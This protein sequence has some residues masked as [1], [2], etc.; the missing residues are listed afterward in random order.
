M[1]ALW[2]ANLPGGAYRNPILYADYS[3]PDIICVGDDFYMVA[4]SF[5]YLPGVP[6]LHS[7]DL[8]NWEI[9]NYCVQSLPFAHYDVPQHGSGTWAPAIRYHEG[10][11]YVFIPLPDEGIFVATA[12]DPY[13]AWDIHCLQEAKGW[14]D[15]CPFWDDDGKAYMV[16][17]Y[18]RSRCGIKHRLSICEIDTHAKRVLSQPELVFDGELTNPTME[19]PKLYKRNGYY[20]IF[21]PAGGVATGWQTV[22]RAK[23]IYGPYEYKIVMH[24]GNTKVNGPHQGGYVDLPNGKS[25]FLHFQ[26]VGAMGRILHMQPMC[27]Q[28]DWPFIGTEQNGDAVGE[29]VGSWP[30]PLPAVASEYYIPTSDNFATEQLGL[31]WQWQANPNKSWYALAGNGLQ[32]Y[33]RTFGNSQ[34]VV[35]QAPNVCT[36]I[37]QAPS[38]TVTVTL[39]LKQPQAGDFAAVGI[40]GHA[41]SYAALAYGQ[42]GYSL[43]LWKCDV[44]ETE[45]NGTALETCLESLPLEGEQLVL[46][47][48]MRQ[49]N[50][51]TYEYAADSKAFAEIPGLYTATPCSW[52]GAKFFLFAGNKQEE[53]TNGYAQYTSV[54]F[55]S[56]VD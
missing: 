49:D 52:T 10:T 18:A 39:A 43:Q 13:G 17:A 8:V 29:P 35:W 22:L 56:M 37:L 48:T 7:K 32:L 23:N 34:G 38:F 24:Q 5:T 1:P 19:G 30:A 11:F 25:Y 6:L 42:G 44:L 21:A 12:T 3:D 33:C 47:I 9:I 15:P 16:F 45:Y 40:L 53:N 4:S 14:I 36:Q 28:A 27:W 51:Y 46:R 31:Q 50:S 54:E 2:N 55:A 41:Y 20:Y 26:D